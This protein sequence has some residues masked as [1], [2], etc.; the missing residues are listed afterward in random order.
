VTPDADVVWEYV[1]FG[2]AAAAPRAQNNMVFRAYR[3]T[4]EEIAAAESA[5]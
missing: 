5:I 3:Y 2:P 1:N 4:P